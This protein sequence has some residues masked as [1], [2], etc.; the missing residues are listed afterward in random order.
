MDNN[1]IIQ[2]EKL[3]VIS[4]EELIAIPVK[5]YEHLKQCEKRLLDMQNEMISALRNRIFNDFQQVNIC[6]QVK[7]Y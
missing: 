1:K 7:N 3:M 4:T 2:G 5:K 6:Q